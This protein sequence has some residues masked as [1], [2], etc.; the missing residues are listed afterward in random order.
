MIDLTIG[1]LKFEY[2]KDS[3]LDGII[4]EIYIKS[5]LSKLPEEKN[6]IHNDKRYGLYHTFH[7][8]TQSWITVY[9]F[10]VPS[11]C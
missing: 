4:G 7:S 10:P 8:S 3:E 5:L 2:M 1:Q 6:T 9:I 11:H